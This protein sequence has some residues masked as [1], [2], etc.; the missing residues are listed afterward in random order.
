MPEPSKNRTIKKNYSIKISGEL[1]Y[2]KK[3]EIIEKILKLYPDEKLDLKYSNEF[4]LL[5]A[6][7]LAARSKDEIVNSATERLFQVYNSPDQFAKLK[8]EDLKP[9]VS[10]INFWYKK[11]EAIIQ[12]SRELLEKY[13]GKVPQSKE[14]LEKI[15]G[16]GSK[17]ASLVV[18]AAFGKPAIIVDTH[19]Q[20]VAKRLGLISEQESDKPQKIE[21]KMK[22]I[23]P[24][25]KQ[26]KFSFA[27]IRHGKKFCSIRNP[28]CSTCPL[29]E[30]C[31]FYSLN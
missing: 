23:V 14:E 26:A 17:T 3:I 24:E 30:D 7:V 21:D 16:I 1:S 11:S 18:A 28:K 12:I 29:R 4:E 31:R 6:A 10:K 20:T 19:F 27:L 25:N 5:V 2:D 8:P 15:K 9:F 13:G 22:K